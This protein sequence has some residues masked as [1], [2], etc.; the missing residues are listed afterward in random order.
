MALTEL[1]KARAEACLGSWKDNA[2][3]SLRLA[4]VQVTTNTPV[5]KVMRK[6]RGGVGGEVERK[7]ELQ[8]R[9]ILKCIP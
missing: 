6:R 4:E 8:M 9:L 3:L 1:K 5:E 2:E 7:L